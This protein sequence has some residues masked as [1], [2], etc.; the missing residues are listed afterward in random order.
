MSLS[1]K[2]QI[3]LCTRVKP[4]LRNSWSHQLFS[5]LTHLPFS[6]VFPHE[7]HAVW[8]EPMQQAGGGGASYS[9]CFPQHRLLLLLLMLL[10]L[11]L[12]ARAQRGSDSGSQTRGSSCRASEYENRSSKLEHIEVS[13]AAQTLFFFPFPFLI[14]Q[15]ISWVQHVWIRKPRT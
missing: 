11:L 4:G 9:C 6:L 12:S 3:H 14:T 5:F 10:L 2:P 8:Q 7:P 1:H 15:S 13:F